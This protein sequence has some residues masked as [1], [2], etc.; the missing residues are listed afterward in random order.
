M[1]LKQLNKQY[2]LKKDMY[3]AVLNGISSNLM[4]YRNGIMYLE[5]VLTSKW[6]KSYDFT[7]YQLAHDWKNSFKSLENAIGCKVFIVD[8][9]Q[10]TSKGYG[11]SKSFST[12]AYRA[13]KGILF[14]SDQLN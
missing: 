4:S 3:T 7:A 6:K 13:K 8:H 9:R 5:V 11:E 1:D 10:K 2:F 14:R 12:K